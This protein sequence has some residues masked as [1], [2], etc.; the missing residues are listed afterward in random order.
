MTNW[1]ES[2]DLVIIGSG[3]GGLC[4][5]LTAHDAGA[6]VVVL[7]KERL[8]GGS[9]AMS[10]GVLWVPNHPLQTGDSVAAAA[11]YLDAVA[12]IPELGSTPRRR[13][14]YLKTAP[15]LVS[16]LM[17]KG[18]KF[19]RDERPDYY[20]ELPGGSV[21]G[22][23][24]VVPLFDLRKLGAW[25]DKLR[26]GP[27]PLPVQGAEGRL[28]TLAGRTP[29]GMLVALRVYFRKYA[30]RLMGWKLVGLG[31]ALQGRMLEILLRAGINIKLESPVVDFVVEGERVA[32]V[33]IGRGGGMRRV[34]A[35][36]GVLIASGGFA[37]NREMRE[38]WQ[39]KPTSTEW[40]NSSTGETGEMIEAAIRLGA[41]VHNTQEAIWIASSLMPSRATPA[42]HATELAKPH[43][44]VVNQSGKR[45]FDE[46]GSYMEAGQRIYSDGSVPCWAIMESRHRNKYNWGKIPPRLS[47]ASWLTSGYMKKA[48]TI[49]QLAGMCAIEPA[50]LK[51]T[52]DR[53]NQ[54]AY[55]G[56]DLDFK[57]GDR[58][59]DRYWGDPTVRPNPSLGAISRAPY[60]AVAL[61]PGDVG[62]FGG[63]VTDE[64]GRVLRADDSPIPGLYATGNATASVVGKSYPGAGASIA[65]SF[66]FGHLATKHALGSTKVQDCLP[67]AF[68]RRL[69]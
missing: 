57:R 35:R 18:L 29:R 38:R 46:A 1:D 66:V 51:E 6:Q 27:I 43:I 25:Q 31:A 53:F 54:F 42:M 40:T 3:G 13:A 45:F 67:S 15:E 26:A 37:R 14:A 19:V 39:P 58:A 48:D 16:F 52:I 69:A 49:E 32:G 21:E 55:R 7:E 9:T 12:G 65:A 63:L 44:I 34:E 11:R 33:I 64:H 47:P 60:Y 2:V 62:T 10:G 8:A 68:A 17:S 5:A 41:A 23:S 4:A 56:R 50:A 22:R 36:K 61:Y 30:M 59:Y 28:L 20:D 24:L